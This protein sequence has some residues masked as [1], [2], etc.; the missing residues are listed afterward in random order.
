MI[1]YDCI[2]FYAIVYYSISTYIIVYYSILWYIKVYYGILKYIIVYY[3]I[4]FGILLVYPRREFMRCLE[5]QGDLVS[6]LAGR[7]TWV[8]LLTVRVHVKRSTGVLQNMH[9]YVVESSWADRA[10]RFDIA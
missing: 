1:V 10:K 8:I 2:L 7:I 9:T 6:R 3:S 4:Y 5:D